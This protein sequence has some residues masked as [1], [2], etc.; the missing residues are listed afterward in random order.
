MSYVLC[1]SSSVCPNW[2]NLRLF[3]LICV[4]DVNKYA[5]VESFHYIY[6]VYLTHATTVV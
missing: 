1:P 3:G 4:K 6:K 5:E 2:R